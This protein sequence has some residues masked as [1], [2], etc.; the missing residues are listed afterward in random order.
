[1]DPE[2]PTAIQTLDD[3]ASELALRGVDE[4]TTDAEGRD[5][6]LPWPE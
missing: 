2:E 6:K 1:L 4:F 3:I 5:E